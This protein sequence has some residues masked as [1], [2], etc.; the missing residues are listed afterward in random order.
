MSEPGLLADKPEVVEQQGRLLWEKRLLLALGDGVAVAVAFVLAF[1][2]RSAEIRHEFFSIPRV[3]LLI[4]LTTWYVCAEISNG[5]RIISAMNLRAAFATAASALSLSFIVL[6]GVFFVVPYRI[7]RP[8]ILLWVPLAAALILAWRAAFQQI[9]ARS[10]FAGNLIVIADQS[11][12]ERIWAEASAGLPE[13]YH[14]SQIVEPQRP[15]LAAYL[16]RAVD[17]PAPPDVIIGVREGLSR[18]LLRSLVACCGTPVR[19]RF[20]TDLFEEMTGRTLLDQIG[21]AWIMSLPAHEGGFG[22][23]AFLKRALDVLI[24]AAGAIL[25]LLLCPF[26]ALAIKAEDRGPVFYR[27]TR[28]GRFGRPFEILKIRT[29][30]DGDKIGERQTE[31]RDSRV[32]LVGRMLRPLHLD[33]LPQ[34]IN[35]LRGEMSLVGPRPE[36]LLHAANLDRQLDFYSLRL[37][38]RPGLTGWAQVNFGYGAGIEGARKKLSYDLYYV[39]RQSLGLDLLILARTIRA[40]VSFQGQ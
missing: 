39:R 14:V 34:A 37:L 20:L 1:N 8:T 13:L 15:D 18:D 36:Q 4:V 30:R 35:I 26:T 5:Y 38:V 21:Y 32:T 25:L 7:T 23:Y 2:L 27:Q 17:D 6:L 31:R 10:F 19:V 3:P 11:S 22:V 28:V 12:F 29:M 24:G 9:F 33:E 16:A 40:I